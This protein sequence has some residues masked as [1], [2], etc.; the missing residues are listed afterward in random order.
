MPRICVV[1]ALLVSLSQVACGGDDSDPE[2]VDAGQKRTQTTQQPSIGTIATPEIGCDMDTPQPTHCGDT[3]CPA[4]PQTPAG[5]CGAVVCCTPQQKCGIRSATTLNGQ[6]ALDLCVAPVEPD[7]RCPEASFASTPGPGCCDL[8]GHCGLLLGGA[9]C[10][11]VP[12]GRA[13]DAAA[14]DAG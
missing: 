7:P 5:V 8:T 13:C 11:P 4:P 10:L 3:E 2:V 14:A 1:A 9:V 6:L 12:S